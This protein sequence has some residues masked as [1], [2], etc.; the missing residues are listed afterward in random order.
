MLNTE[1][2]MKIGAFFYHAGD[3]VQRVYE[4][5]VIPELARVSEGHAL[6]TTYDYVIRLLDSEFLGHDNK[7]VQISVFD[8]MRK[9]SNEKWQ[10]SLARLCQQLKFCGYN[11]ETDEKMLK[12]KVITNC[13]DVGMR[14]KLMKKERSLTDVWRSSHRINSVNAKATDRQ[15]PTGDE[16]KAV[17]QKPKNGLT[18]LNCGFDGHSRGDGSCPAKGKPCNG[19][20]RI[21]HNRSAGRKS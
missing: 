6:V 21:G 17:I 14:A 4:H 20:K 12:Q 19:C 5:V 1:D 7:S 9:Q 16:V 10:A 18:W 3:D 11:A 13:L 15:S 2:P 8:G